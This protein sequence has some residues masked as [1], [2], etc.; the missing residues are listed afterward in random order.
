MSNTQDTQLVDN[1]LNE[2]IAMRDKLN[3]LINKRIAFL[4]D[5]DQIE[6]FPGK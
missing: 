1:E 4:T 5:Q 3:E 2:L 6:L